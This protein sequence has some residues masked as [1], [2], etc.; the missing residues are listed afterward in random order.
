MART[1]QTPRFKYRS[2][3]NLI[4]N[5]QDRPYVETKPSKFKHI[6]YNYGPKDILYFKKYAYKHIHTLYAKEEVV[7][8]IV[9]RYSKNIRHLELYEGSFVHGTCKSLQSFR[10]YFTK[11][12]LQSSM[13]KA[14]LRGAP[15]IQKI[16][17]RN[18][19]E[20]K[21]ILPYLRKFSWL[22]SL[23]Y[24]IMDK[25]T[26]PAR[27]LGMLKNMRRLAH[28]AVQIN[29]S[30]L[31]P[32]VANDIA[33]IMRFMMSLSKLKSLVFEFLHDPEN[34]KKEDYIKFLEE[35]YSKKMEKLIFKEIL[36]PNNY[37]IPQQRVNYL[38]ISNYEYEYE[39]KEFFGETCNELI[40]ASSKV[41]IY[42]L[43]TRSRQ[44]GAKI[45]PK[46][47]SVDYFHL[48]F[49]RVPMTNINDFFPASFN[50]LKGLILEFDSNPET[51]HQ[52]LQLSMQAIKDPSTTQL[53][54][55]AFNDLAPQPDVIHKFF[56][57][58]SISELSLVCDVI[59]DNSDSILKTLEGLPLNKNL[60]KLQLDLS[61]GDPEIKLDNLMTSVSNMTEL[62][63]LKLIVKTYALDPIESDLGF[64]R[65][66]KT[67]SSL[68]LDFY[69]ADST[70]FFDNLSDYLKTSPTLSNFELSLHEQSYEIS[71]FKR[72]LSDLCN[73][74]KISSINMSFG[75]LNDEIGEGRWRFLLSDQPK[76][77]RDEEFK[78][79][80]QQQLRNIINCF[81]PG[82]FVLSYKN[83]LL[84]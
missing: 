75:I 4:P 74:D 37:Y 34:A 77:K 25:I 65:T 45:K 73:L 40:K 54:A 79:S 2:T 39:V 8:K 78:F 29:T 11:S 55:L 19:E 9:T 18:L 46:E 66:L 10:L 33:G 7:P 23:T 32:V 13:V 30:G 59:R 81:K 6:Y 26:N 44:K 21:P 61:L 72:I 36:C 56:S 62:S 3:S 76:K 41:L 70:S 42:E 15:N 69:P 82:L 24:T 83:P 31:S 16:T 58:L 12:Q 35:M 43:D 50:G 51:F 1:K 28:L 68:S 57:F 22:N 80:Q 47:A 63:S 38:S 48:R 49:P 52:V 71:D 14:M 53:L 64:L 67:L 17:L 5:T 84:F 60:K 20:A 27:Q